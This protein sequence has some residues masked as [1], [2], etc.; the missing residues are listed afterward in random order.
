MYFPIFSIYKNL[1]KVYILL[2][3]DDCVYI[4]N[5]Y[6]MFKYSLLEIKTTGVQFHT[7]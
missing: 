5:V 2:Y 7:L 4:N 3:K 1:I 6:L